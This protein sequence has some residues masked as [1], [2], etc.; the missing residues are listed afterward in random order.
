MTKSQLKLAFAVLV[1]VLVILSPPIALSQQQTQPTSNQSDSKT[2]TDEP[3]AMSVDELEKLRVAVENDGDLTEDVKNNILGFVDR[4]IVLREGENQLR[5]ETEELKQKINIAPERIR[6]IEAE[7]D[8]PL[9][10]DEKI[11][12]TASNMDLG[13]LEHNLRDLETKLSDAKANLAKLTDQLD[14]ISNRPAKSQQG[15]VNNKQLLKEIASD[16]QTAPS[17]DEP[18]VL[19]R[20]RRAALLAQQANLGIEIELLEDQLENQDILMALNSAER[21]LAAREVIRQ[22]ALFK[23]WQ[24]EVQRIRELEAKKERVVAEQAKKVAVDLPTVVQKQFDIN[25]E[26]GKLLEKVTAEEANIVENLGRRKALLKQI[27]DEFAFAREQ[28]GFHMQTTETLGLALREQRRA[29]PSIGNFRRESTLRQSQLGEIQSKQLELDIQRRGLADLDQAVERIMEEEPKLPD[30]EMNVLKTELRRLLSD[31]RD[32]VKKLQ[33]GYRRSFKEIQSLEFIEQQIAA[34]AEEVAKFLDEHLLW[35]RSA[36]SIGVQDLRNLPSSVK[37]MLN[38]YHW[39]QVAGDL[40]LSFVQKPIRWILVLLVS[41]FFVGLRRWSHRDLSQI[42]R[43]VYSVKTDSFVLTLRALANTGRV[44]LGWPLLLIFTGWQLNRL[45]MAQDFTHAMSSG[46]IV[47]AQALAAGLLLY[48]LCWMEGVAKVHFKWTESIRRSIRRSL[49]WFIPLAT[50]MTFVVYSVQTTNNAIYIDSLGRLALITDMIVFSFWGAYMLRF[51]GDIV[52]MLKSKSRQGWLVRLRFFWYPLAVGV[53]L[54]LAFVAGMGYHY[55]AFA[56]YER[57]GETIALIFGLILVK[58]LVLRWLSISKRRLAYEEAQRKKEVEQEGK[59]QMSDVGFEGE[60]A[61]IEE[62][63]IDLDQIYEQNQALLRTMLFFTSLVGLWAIWANVLPALNIL[64]KVQLWSYSSEVEGVRTTIPITLA[65]LMLAIIVIIVTVVATKNLPGLLEIIL[66]NWLPMNAGSRYATT[67]IC[68]YA[69]T[70]VGIVIAFTTIGL[71]WSNI[72][73]LIAALSVGLGF[74]LQEIVSNF[75]SGLIVLF[76]QPFRIGDTVTIGDVS[77]TVTRIRIRATT[78]IDW[79]RKEL[80]V[81]NKEFITGRLINWSL[82]DNIVRIRIPIGIAYG[83]DT[84][85]AE[86]LMLKAA[87]ANSLVR[88]NPQPQAVFLGFGDNSLNFELRVFINGIDDWIPMLHKLNRAVDREFRKASVTISFPQ[89]DVHLD[90]IGPLEVRVV[91][92]GM[93]SQQG[94]AAMNPPHKAT[95]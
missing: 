79:D 43:S 46:L 39:W 28:V 36:K 25:I 64:E 72:Q 55:S 31:R 73:W 22:E 67:T 68:S 26:L 2:V 66:L 7:L 61:I 18:K 54:T 74:G 50:S 59:E 13:Q 20:A 77:G 48:E 41:L 27:E 5:K 65:D 89:R 95:S 56:L 10:S 40:G 45:S 69:I 35:I 3:G 75:I 93:V 80:I 21:D 78:I 4:A 6:A 84:D 37:W 60:G 94:N 29:L 23:K 87:K 9:P 47:A 90:Q 82:S 24:A 11:A 15:I 16:L 17:A 76:E 57:M 91:G 33:A 30:T 44:V 88:E 53:P 58:D 62:P 14:S 49:Q 70:A 42:A 19:V 38:P 92:D 12:T 85:L 8:R 32:L 81:P 83:S 1:L 71:K 51:S 63:E 34:K 52:T 86:K